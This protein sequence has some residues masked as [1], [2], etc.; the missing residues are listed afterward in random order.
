M[1]MPRCAA[2]VALSA[3]VCARHVSG[4]VPQPASLPYASR[5]A[6]AAR[7]GTMQMISFP[8]IFKSPEKEATPEA[9]GEVEAKPAWAK[10]ETLA[11]KTG[12]ASPADVGLI[13]TVAVDFA[14]IGD[15]TGEE[16][17]STMAIP[18]QPLSEVATQADAF[19]KYKCGKGECGTCEVQ[20]DGKWIRT[21]QTR[22]PSLA[23]GETY[24]VRI[25]PGAVKTEAS[26][27]FF[28]AKSF[29]DGFVNN[30]LG[31]YGLVAEGAKEDDNFNLRMDKEAAIKAKV[32]AKKAAK[33]AKDGPRP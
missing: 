14:I 9:A 15:E 8:D 33:A 13:G 32:A 20:V 18:G 29:R 16:T 5:G 12:S 22:V 2:L 24:S 17:K 25:R 26:S 31:M 11:S 27:G 19:I 21:C 30:A 3:F 4:F 6:T 23:A 10:K 28:S 7:R 1:V